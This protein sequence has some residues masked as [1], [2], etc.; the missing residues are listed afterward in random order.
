MSDS[1]S[2]TVSSRLHEVAL[3]HRGPVEPGVYRAAQGAANQFPILL[4]IEGLAMTS[5]PEGEQAH[6][7]ELPVQQLRRRTDHQPHHY[8]QQPERLPGHDTRPWWV[9]VSGG[10]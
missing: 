1:K 5:R 3:M 9:E 7:T 10:G 2:R 4:G 6:A 8:R